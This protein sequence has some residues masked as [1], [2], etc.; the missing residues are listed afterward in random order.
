[1]T[2]SEPRPFFP[3][4]LFLLA[5]M[6]ALSPLSVDLYLPAFPAIAQSLGVQSADVQIT[7]AVFLFGMS[8]GQL[9]YGPLSDRYGRKP[10]LYFGLTL[11][12]L[13]SVGCMLATDLTTL[14]VA[15]FLQALG[16]SA[17]VVVG[18]AV[19]RDRTTT[20]Q[21][22]W[23]FSMLMLA[24]GLAP[25]LAPVLGSLLLEI[26]G[27]REIFAILA[28]AGSIL[29]LAMHFTMRETLSRHAAERLGVAGTF[30]RYADLLRDRQ[31]IMYVLIGAL[32]F[33]GMFAYVAGSPYVIIELY[34]VPAVHFGWFFGMNA[35]G[36]IAG[37]QVN[38]RLVARFG[39]AALLNAMLWPPFL[40]ASVALLATLLGFA[41]LPLLM[42]CFFVYMTSMG[43][44]SPN[45]VA[46]AMASQGQRAGS[47]SAVIGAIQFFLGTLGAI[48]VS[49][50]IMPS[51]V[52]LT[53][54][55][56]TLTGFSL[57]IHQFG[58]RRNILILHGS[59]I[60]QP[61]QQ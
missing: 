27:W 26:M 29:I 7:L 18:R 11:F 44:L 9:I 49:V 5:M 42:A 51:A 4:W 36:M 48:A 54:V 32:P 21:A 35:F 24:L 19:I 22:A 20:A 33:G 46:L 57:L 10:P 47:A 6:T 43:L 37:S 58:H 39:P 59:D 25:I 15:R 13:A 23:A 41:S 50:W 34:E 14:T 52:P 3:G 8:L 61:T 30:K 55:M 38:A 31:F 56:V 1:M 60:E 12:I 40:A 17:G 45:A 2:H 16:G 28:I 53:A